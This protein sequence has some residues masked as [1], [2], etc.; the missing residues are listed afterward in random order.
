MELT[1]KSEQKDVSEGELAAMRVLWER[2]PAST[3]QI[4]DAVYPRGGQAQY[5]TVQKQ[6][7]RLEDKGFVHRDR[8]LFVHVFSAAVSRD[9]LVGRRVRAVVDNLCEGSLVPLLTHLA[10]VDEL[11]DAERKALRELVEKHRRA[12][13]AKKPSP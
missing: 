10:Q 4:T 8:S 12:R 3:R 7:E 11:S 5:A 13:T 6:L 1:L 2:G 9:E